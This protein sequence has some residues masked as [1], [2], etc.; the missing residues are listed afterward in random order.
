MCSQNS[1]VHR[2]G[3]IEALKANPSGFLVLLNAPQKQED[4]TI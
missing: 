4:W 2:Q 1:E 3:G